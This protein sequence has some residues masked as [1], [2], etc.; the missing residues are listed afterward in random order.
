MLASIIRTLVPLIVGFGLTWAAK[1]GLDIHADTTVTDLVTIV[2]VGAYYGAV[3]F[4]EQT[5]PGLGQWLLAFGLTRK[6]PTYV[7]S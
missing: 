1:L 4:L 7:K 3:R 5:W 6:Q 2:L